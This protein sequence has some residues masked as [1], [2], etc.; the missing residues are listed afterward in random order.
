[1]GVYVCMHVLHAPNRSPNTPSVF[2]QP[3]VKL[4]SITGVIRPSVMGPNGASDE[5][6]STE[7]VSALGPQD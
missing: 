4:N 7:A 2:P 5:T 1:M 3:S 6:A